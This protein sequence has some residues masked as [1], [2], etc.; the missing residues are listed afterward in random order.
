MALLALTLLLV[1]QTVH[2]EGTT[3]PPL[4]PLTQD[5]RAAVAHELEEAILA[6]AS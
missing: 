5:E 2:A 3:L 1:A 6:L 4:A